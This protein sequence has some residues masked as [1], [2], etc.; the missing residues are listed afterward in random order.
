MGK[1]LV[2]AI[3]LVFDN[4][5]LPYDYRSDLPCCF[6]RWWWWPNSFL[7]TL[8]SCYVFEEYL[9]PGRINISLP[10]RNYYFSSGRVDTA[11][12]MHYMDTNYTDGEKGLTAT[13][14][15]C[16]EQYWTSPG[17]NNPQS[18]S[19]T[20]TN[21]PS[22]KLSELDEPDMENTAGKVRTSL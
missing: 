9:F 11:I 5:P 7:F 17:G 4:P 16:F 15:H 10:L 19:Y 20:A 13:T 22:R 18:S 14:Q 12:W 3:S 6:R 2:T 21:H 8:G 1:W